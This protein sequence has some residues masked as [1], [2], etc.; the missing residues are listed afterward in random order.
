MLFQ[1]RKIYDLHT[2]GT[3]RPFIFTEGRDGQEQAL[4]AHDIE[5]AVKEFRCAV[6]EHDFFLRHIIKRSDRRLQDTRLRVRI[7]DDAIQMGK[8]GFPHTR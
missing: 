6:A 5:E 1:Q 3:R 4:R 2:C 8:N 7:I